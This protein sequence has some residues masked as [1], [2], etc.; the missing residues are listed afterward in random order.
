MSEP[1]HTFSSAALWPITSIFPVPSIGGGLLVVFTVSVTGTVAPGVRTTVEWSNE[2]E[3][4]AP[5]QDT[6]PAVVHV[7]LPGR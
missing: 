5:L 7:Q 1:S 2:A 4:P 3:D 6:L